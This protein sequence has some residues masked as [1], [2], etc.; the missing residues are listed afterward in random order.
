ML[1]AVYFVEGRMISLYLIL[2]VVSV[3]GA[4][5]VV[6]LRKLA[7]R[8]A[9]AGSPHEWLENFSPESYAPMG[10]LLDERDFAFLARQPGYDAG[11]AKRLRAE[12]KAVFQAYL[13]RLVRDF[14]QLVATAKLMLVFSDE[15]RT[16]FARS[17]WRQQVT[18]Y[19]AVSVLRLRL[20]FYPLV[21]GSWDLQGVLGTL[22]NVHNDLL[23]VVVPHPAL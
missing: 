7:S 11:I 8:P 9:N 13:G 3:I 14:N 12:R 19:F 22:R 16:D 17:L 21:L 15:D 18:F 1:D 4:G 6:L 20:A 10:R 5:F 23:G 2:V